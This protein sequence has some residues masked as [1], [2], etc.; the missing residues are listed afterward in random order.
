[1]ATAAAHVMFD[2][3]GQPFIILRDQEKQ[4]RLTGIEALKVLISHNI[5]KRR[6][7]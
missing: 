4:K 6:Y 7:F 5:K 2:E 1:M 3:Y